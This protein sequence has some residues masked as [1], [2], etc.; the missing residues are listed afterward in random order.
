MSKQNGIMVN[1][2]LYLFVEVDKPLDGRLCNGCDA[3][4]LGKDYR[5]ICDNC[6]ELDGHAS[7][8]KTIIVRKA[9]YKIIEEAEK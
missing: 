7:E 2:D 8:S 6:V 4:M 3:V 5:A 1:G 9:N